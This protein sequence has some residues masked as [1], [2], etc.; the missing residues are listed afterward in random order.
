MNFDIFIKGIIIGLSVS[1]PMGPIG[2]LCIQ[3]T[4]NRGQKYGIATG[5][6]ATVSDLIYSV[7]TIFF[8]NIVLD[9]IE[10]R[11]LIIQIIGSI[12]I[13]FFGLWIFNSHPSKQPLPNEK[14]SDNSLFSD[15]FTSTALTLSN[16][17][18]LFVLIALFS[19]FDFIHPEFSIWGHAF[20]LFSILIGATIWWITLTGLVNRFRYRFSIRGLKIINRLTGGVIIIIGFVGAL[21]G[22][23]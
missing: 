23:F 11:K 18:I 22:L 1:V 6:G 14:H 20:A 15:F 3:R 10:E 17:L 2:M 13:I 16:P 8:L 21:M 5:L 12:I 9:F 19:Q 7:I 4:L